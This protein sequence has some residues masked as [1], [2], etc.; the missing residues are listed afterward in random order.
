MSDV[1]QIKRKTIEVEFPDGSK[2]TLTR[3]TIKQARE[4]EKAVKESEPDKTIDL[5]VE[6]LEKCGLS[7][8]QFE[9][10]FTTEDVIE[11]YVN[12]LGSKK[13]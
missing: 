5:L 11:L 8:E 6:F 2:V 13:K 12:L 4:I 7:K 3:P 10:N 9:D 1:Y